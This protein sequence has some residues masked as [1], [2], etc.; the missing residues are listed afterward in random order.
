MIKGE[1]IKEIKMNRNDIDDESQIKMVEF[2]DAL[3]QL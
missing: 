3:W 1:H 2:R